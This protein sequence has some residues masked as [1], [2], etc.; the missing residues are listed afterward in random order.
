MKMDSNSLFLFFLL[1]LQ[2]YFPLFPLPKTG[3]RM[4]RDLFLLVDISSK[5]HEAFKMHN[6]YSCYPLGPFPGTQCCHSVMC[7]INVFLNAL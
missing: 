3:S 7:Q 4:L 6:Y 2:L 1:F 5:R